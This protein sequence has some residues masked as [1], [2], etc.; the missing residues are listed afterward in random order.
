[1][2][3]IFVFRSQFIIDETEYIGGAMKSLFVGGGRTRLPKFKLLAGP[4]SHRVIRD[5]TNTDET[6]QNANYL[7]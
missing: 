5:F 7:T 1:M 3:C 2:N 6:I 4:I